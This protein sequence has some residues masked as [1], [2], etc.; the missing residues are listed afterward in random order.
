MNGRAI[1]SANWV[2]FSAA[3]RPS[4][5]TAP[6]TI[7]LG[8]MLIDRV[9]NLRTQGV[10]F[11]CKAPSLSIWPAIVQ[12]M[13][14]EVP[15]K[16]RARAKIVPAIGASVLDRRSWIPNRL[17]V[18]AAELVESEAPAT[19]RMALLTKSAN[20]KSEII[21][22]AVE[23]DRHERIA[24]RDGRCTFLLLRSVKSELL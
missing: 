12:T 18:S 9:S 22:S 16:S 24:A 2:P 10:V 8:T 23:Y 13:P 1:L 3:D 4:L 7:M 20:V 11:Q 17:L 6:A 19:M 14:A 15:D 5:P 21:T